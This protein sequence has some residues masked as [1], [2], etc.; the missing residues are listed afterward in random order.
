MSAASNASEPLPPLPAWQTVIGW[1]LIGIACFVTLAIAVTAG[2]AYAAGQKIGRMFAVG[3][4]SSFLAW[5]A[6]YGRS[7]AAKA[8]ARIVLGILLVIVAFTM[9]GSGKGVNEKAVAKKFLQDAVALNKKHEQRF[10]ELGERMGKSD[11]SNVLAPATVTTKTRIANSLEQVA[12]YRSLVRER[13]TILKENLEEGRQLVLNL[14]PGEVRTN[15]ESVIVKK[16]KEAAGLFVD[17]DRAEL[18][19]L[20]LVDKI[21][22]WCAQQ[23]STLK[24]QQGQF[25]FASVNQQSQ[26]NAM[27]EELQKIELEVGYASKAVERKATRLEAK[28]QE[29]LKKANKLLAN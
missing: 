14:P 3:V 18:A 25:L 9:A 23:G 21:L 5:A 17:I 27:I 28:N 1:L 11:L 20:A 12:A 4:F 15:A 26:F 8:N 7:Q 22:D 6:T 19:H 24:H 29:N 16:G 10:V 13:G 2:D